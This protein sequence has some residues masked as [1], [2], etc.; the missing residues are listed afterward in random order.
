MAAPAPEGVATLSGILKSIWAMKWSRVATR[1]DGQAIESELPIEPGD[2]RKFLMHATCSLKIAGESLAVPARC[3]S[4]A[5]AIAL[6][7]PC[8]IHSEGRCSIVASETLA[9]S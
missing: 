7:S 8:K 2:R 3:D 4:D 5:V 1:T 9:R 6:N